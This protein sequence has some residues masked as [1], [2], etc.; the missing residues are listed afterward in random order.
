MTNR[1]M[2]IVRM[3]KRPYDPMVMTN[4]PMTKSPRTNKSYI[5]PILDYCS[6]VWAPCTQVD[7][8]LVESVQR[9][10][11]RKIPG[12]QYMTYSDIYFVA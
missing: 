5:L 10:F 9:N 8:K 11:T 6:T 4:S 2:S 7:I 3:T 12:L 1:H